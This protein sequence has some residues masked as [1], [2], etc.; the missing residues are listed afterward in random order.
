VGTGFPGVVLG[1]VSIPENL[2]AESSVIQLLHSRYPL[3]HKLVCLGSIVTFF[4]IIV[5]GGDRSGCFIDGVFSVPRF[6][7]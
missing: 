1:T 7:V 2:V 6:W 4:I 5:S 3:E